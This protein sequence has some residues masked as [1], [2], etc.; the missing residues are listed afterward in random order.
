[1]GNLKFGDVYTK[2]LDLV[3]Q[4]PPVYNFP[5]KDVTT[6]HIPG[7]NGDLTI[8]NKCW[9]NVERT[10][11]LAAVFRPNSNFIENA[12]KL[13]KFLTAKS[14]YQRLEDSYDP[15]VYRM[16]QFKSNGALQNYY[17]EA[18]AINVT[19]DCKPQRY[20]KDG[21]IPVLF[22]GSSA[23]LENPTGRPALPIICIN[24]VTHVDN[25]VLLVTI[26]NNDKVTSTITISDVPSG[27]VIIDSEMQTVASEENGDINDCVSLNDKEFPVLGEGETEVAIDKY[28]EQT[29]V[30]EKYDIIMSNNKQTCLALYKPYDAIVES[31]QKTFAVKSY[32]LLKQ[33]VQEIYQ[34]DAYGNYCLSYAKN[35]GGNYT[36]ISFNTVMS[37]TSQSYSFQTDYSSKPAW[38]NISTSNGKIIVTVGDLSSFDDQDS[39]ISTTYAYFISSSDKVVRRLQTGWKIGEFAESATVTITVYP[40]HKS[41]GNLKV[42]YSGYDLPSW[43]SFEVTYDKTYNDSISGQNNV[44]VLKALSY[45]SNAAGYYYLPKSGLFGKAGWA[46]LSSGTVLT[47][48]EWSSY[49]KAFMP[50]GIS[51][52]ATASFEYSYLESAPQYET[53]YIDKV[54]ENGNV[55]KDANGNPIKEPSNKVHFN[56]VALDATLTSIKYTAIDTGYFRCNDGD[57]GTAWRK[58]TAGS[59]IPAACGFA[60]TVGAPNMV[61]YMESLP[62]YDKVDGFPEW[63]DP[64]PVLSGSD[65]ANGNPTTIELKVKVADWY[66]CTYISSGEELYTAW[67]YLA[68]NATL[69]SIGHS[70]GPD[71]SYSAYMVEGESGT[72]PIKT[73]TYIDSDGHQINDIGFFYLDSEGHQIEYPDNLPPSWLKVDVIPGVNEDGSDTTLEFRANAAGSFNWDANTVWINKQ[74]GGELV[75]STNKDDTTVNYLASTPSYPTSYPLYDITVNKNAITGNPESISFTVKSGKA[76]Y[77]RAKNSSNWK[78]YEDGEEICNSKISE[79]TTIYNLQVASGSL[80]SLEISITPRWWDL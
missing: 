37:A 5:A 46:T 31:K 44:W 68:V 40:A 9:Q 23:T 22:S 13:V 1:M 7:R 19:F 67:T 10:Y 16:A 20:L 14:G 34:A 25:Q 15:K 17:D 39:N 50:S 11:S 29:T 28:T 54:D 72:F 43:L 71:D 65:V 56:V 76:G 30:I 21:E 62:T 80:S 24:G 12:E 3:I 59:D 64:N 4:A 77:F 60:N 26:R 79:T 42:D 75:T 78:Y 58:V 36:F 52:S 53:I 32:N 2:D 47:T 66:R 69:G 74:V 57:Q 38:L 63:L 45:K 49:K 6:E 73:Y 27:D 55:I 35:H 51:T 33:Q 18:T 61:Y 41:T 8:D 70:H 48:L